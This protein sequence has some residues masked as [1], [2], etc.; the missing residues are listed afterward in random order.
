MDDLVLYGCWRSST[1]HRLQIGLRLKQLP[2]HYR[3]VN[4]DQG[5]QQSDWYQAINPNGEV[6]AL[7]VNGAIWLESLSILEALEERYGPQGVPLLPSDADARRRCRELCEA[8]NSSMQ[9]L[10]LPGRLR[11]PILDAA[12]AELNDAV[13]AAL[14]TGVQGFQRQ[15]LGRLNRRLEGT[16]G[17]YCLGAQ[18]SLADVL[19]VPQLE[20]AM[21]LGIDLNPYRRLSDLHSACLRL[22]A[23]AA[24]APERQADAPEACAA[25]EP[26]RQRQQ[27]L[28]HKDPEPELAAYLCQVAN[29][30]I[31]GLEPCRRQTLEHFGV[32]ASKMTALD[33]CLLLRWLCRSRQVRRVLEIGVFTG[34]S[35]LAILDG[36][37]ADAELIAIDCEP[38]FTALAEACWQQVGR[39]AQV[40]LLLGDAREL[41]PQLQPGFDLIYVD[42]DNQQY[43]SYLALALPLLSPGGLLVF[44]NVLWRGRV[45]QPQHD[46]SA[47]ALDQLNRLL[48]A[49]PSLHCTV[50]S[51][52]DGMA[53]VERA[54]PQAMAAR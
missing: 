47:I 35:S 5:E 16:P 29:A 33:G 24:A 43:L 34:S 18:L 36:L 6:P 38:R 51:L 44:D 39:R 13:A 50:L 8:I 54:Q 4:L 41:L 48:Q 26:T 53:L 27:L 25:A 31:P 11:R 17:P 40:D 23:F 52:S 37:A 1:S 45:V 21:R 28:A 49:E 32:V 10:L 12:G 46:S 22:E 9:P 42:A 19:V 30:P 14:Q 20:A 15:A 2:F 7:G 3:P